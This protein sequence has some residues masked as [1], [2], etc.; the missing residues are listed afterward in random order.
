MTSLDFLADSIAAGWEP[1]FRGE[2]Y[3]FARTIDLQNG[4]AI[5]GPFE[6][7]KTKY[8]IEPLQ[9]LRNPR[10]RTVIIRKAVQTGGSLLADIWVPY[11][12]RW[13]PGDL[14]WL[15]QDD[16]FAGKYMDERF[17]PGCL[18]RTPG[19]PE[20]LAH[21]GRFALQ[22]HQ[23]LLPLMS[24]MI[25]GL[26]EN[27][28]Q[29]LSKRYLII[30]EAWLSGRSGLISQAK[31]RTTAYP[32]N[33]KTLIISQAGETGDDFDL[34]WQASDQRH[35]HF[36]CPHCQYSQPYEFSRKRDDDSWA[37]MKWDTNDT[38]CPN[39]KWNYDLVARTAR[40]E[41]YHCRQPIPDTPATRRQL[42]DSAHYLPTRPDAET[43]IAGFWWPA[44][45][46]PHTAFGSLVIRYLKAKQQDHDFA[47]QLPL[48]EWYQKY[49]ATPWNPNLTQHLQRAAYEPYDITTDWP[50]EAARFLTVDCQ[51]DLKDFWYVVRAF[52]KTGESRQLDRGRAENWDQI[53]EV[54][55]RWHILDQY[56]FIDAGY[57]Q[58]R[59]ALECV[60]HGHIG[61]A[62]IGN[63]TKKIWFCWTLLKGS[64]LDTFLHPDPLTGAKHRR[65][66]S[67][68][69]W[70]DPHLGR[71]RPA[72]PA[73]APAARVPLYSWSNLHVKDILR[74][75]R[76]QDRAP[77]FLSLPDPEPHDNPWS[78]TA[79]MNSEIRDQIYD[80]KGRKTSVWRPI[81]RRPNHY[82][83]C[84]AMTIA[85]ALIT[86]L[87]GAE[88]EKSEK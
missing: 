88:E 6:I 78:Y 1:P 80:P 14:L 31:A 77:K 15:L 85:A 65:I 20:L 5:K 21:G 23:I 45:A 30:D 79:Q 59:C 86:G 41:C 38:T 19:I 67:R 44:E 43:G 72:G 17:I 50:D 42:N 87:I 18:K 82:W 47:Y 3:D 63:R 46:S 36:R 27:N 22:R 64:G 83:D 56:T 66:I 28:V 7:E 70:I 33:S 16:D 29:A 69:D 25:G 32:W 54:Q 53:A 58:T 57:E 2:I 55:K 84:E 74:R 10:I 51:K 12:I 13:D 37:G 81:P 48:R 11:L 24:V 49:R 73:H 26:N 52:S 40:Y 61:T 4:Y 76:D 9:A 39:G 60:Q 68:L 62:K 35:L 75:H 71:H 8:L 34:E